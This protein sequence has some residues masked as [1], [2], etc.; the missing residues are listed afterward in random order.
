MLLNNKTNGREMAGSNPVGKIKSSSLIREGNQK[1][2]KQ[3]FMGLFAI[4]RV[5]GAV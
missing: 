5:A 1:S 2:Y 4:R 3:E